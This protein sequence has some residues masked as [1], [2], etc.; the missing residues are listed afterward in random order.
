[1]RVFVTG[2]SGWIGSALVPELI[3]AGHHVIG[4][5]RS[6]ASADALTAAGAE[7]L[8]GSLEDL[9]SLKEGAA[10]SDGVIHL[11][12]IHDF[13]RYQAA[14]ETDQQAIAAM[15]SAL[16]GSDRPLVVASGIAA[17]T[18]NG[19][20]TELDPPRPDFPRAHAADMTLAFAEHG[21]RSSIVRLPPTVHGRGDEGFVP[22]LVNVARR[23]GVSGFIG[24]G[25]NRWPAVHRDDA[26]R[27]FRLALEKA[28]AG[29]ILH[30]IADEGVPT[31]SIAEVIGRHLNLP[32]ATVAPEHANDHFSWLGMIFAADLPASS[33]LTRQRI[34]WT[35]TGAGLIDDLD[36]GHY[37]Q[38]PS[39][40]G[41]PL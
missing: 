26:A 2:A 24:E 39:K 6:E 20:A 8:H 15:G 29:S 14:Q 37:F 41:I 21:V 4:L 19:P 23:T 5:A 10:K 12:F 1:M 40:Q 18:S 17:L 30:A 36:Q 32:V 27:L 33:A 7:A 34:G 38:D 22:T 3:E 35:P 25:T 31:R 11:A 28:P 13:S 9:D 16:E